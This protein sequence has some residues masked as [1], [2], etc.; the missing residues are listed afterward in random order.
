MTEKKTDKKDEYIAQLEADLAFYKGLMDTVRKKSR[1]MPDV[2]DALF[3]VI[4]HYQR[5]LKEEAS[6]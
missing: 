4:R 3:G 2:G 1:A 5:K 6:R